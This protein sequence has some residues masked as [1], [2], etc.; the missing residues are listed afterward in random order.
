[1]MLPGPHTSFVLSN[2]LGASTFKVQRLL[3]LNDFTMWRLRKLEFL[4][5][6]KFGCEAFFSIGKQKLEITA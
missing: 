5:A 4:S 3:Q 1:M 2:I 6:G